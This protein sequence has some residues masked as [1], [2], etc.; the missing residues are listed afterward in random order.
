M[1]YRTAKGEKN[2]KQ[3]KKIK[4]LTKKVEEV[5]YSR[6]YEKMGRLLVELIKCR[7]KKEEKGRIV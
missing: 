1:P 6:N 4:I 2:M 5:I 7:T 3:L